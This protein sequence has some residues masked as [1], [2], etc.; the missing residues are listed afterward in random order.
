MLR[1]LK[2]INHDEHISV[3]ALASAN[4]GPVKRK[5]IPLAFRSDFTQTSGCVFRCN[6]PLR[7]RE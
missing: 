1:R 6:V 2:K 3:C 5:E 4:R 7:R